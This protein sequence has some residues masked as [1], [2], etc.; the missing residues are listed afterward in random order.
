[1]SPLRLAGN[2]WSS[3]L[4][5]AGALL[6]AAGGARPSGVHH[7]ALDWVAPRRGPLAWFFRTAGVRAFT[8][9]ATIVHRDAACLDDAA[10]CRHERVHVRQCLVLGPLMPLAYAGSSLWELA[11][12]RHPYRDNWFERHARG[13]IASNR[14]SSPQ[15]PPSR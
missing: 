10:L 4:T 3:P 13:E 14:T 1:M 6:A 8:W 2:V 9:G 12:G 15:I 11:R 5:V 7:G